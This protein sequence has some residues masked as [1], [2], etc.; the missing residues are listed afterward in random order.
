MQRRFKKI[1]GIIVI[2]IAVISSL[3][4]IPQTRDTIN[5]EIIYRFQPLEVYPNKIQVACDGSI[6]LKDIYVRNRVNKNFKNIHLVAIINSTQFT[7]ND[8]QID[9]NPYSNYLYR[10]RDYQMP[11]E[12]LVMHI[13]Q[14]NKPCSIAF[15][16][17]IHPDEQIPYWIW[18]KKDTC[19]EN[20]FIELYI[21]GYEEGT[22]E[23]I[24]DPNLILGDLGNVGCHK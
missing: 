9:P 22:A 11:V 19:N 20:S 6:H 8:F 2:I 4:L 24:V 16:R 18:F 14:D 1:I 7:N 23:S 17:D 12:A 13:V 5:E 3:L 21:N 10:N 15:L